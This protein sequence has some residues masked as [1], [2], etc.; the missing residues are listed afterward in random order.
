M[1]DTDEVLQEVY[2]ERARQL[3][4]WGEQRHDPAWWLVILAEE[5]GE[6]ARAIFEGDT[7]GY[8]EELI[9][10]AAVAV[11]AAEPAI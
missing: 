1:R 2:D 4:K 8:R 11:A 6:V 5:M 10:V 9:Q 3:A 7:R